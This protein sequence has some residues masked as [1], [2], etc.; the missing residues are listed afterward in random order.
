MSHELPAQAMLPWTMCATSAIGNS[1]IC[2]PSNAQPPA[3]APGLGRAQPDFSFLL[4]E[5]AGSSSSAAM[6]LDFIMG[7]Y[8]GSMYAGGKAKAVPD[9]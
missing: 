6:S 2:A 8:L 5:Q 4:W 7:R 3:D 9:A 1:A